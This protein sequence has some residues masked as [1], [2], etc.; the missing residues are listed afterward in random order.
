[1]LSSG[2]LGSFVLGGPDP[3]IR[4]SGVE[5]ETRN[6]RDRGSDLTKQNDTEREQGSTHAMVRPGVPIL[7]K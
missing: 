4:T 7:I 1:M 5:I 2:R 6:A 3:R